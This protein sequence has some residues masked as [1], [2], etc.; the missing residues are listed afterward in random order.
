MISELFSLSALER[1]VDRRT[2]FSVGITLMLLKYVVDA[3]AIW[4][5]AGIL[6]TPFDYFVPLVSLTGA[7]IARFPTE[8]NAFLLCW[9]LIFIWIGVTMSARRA[10]DAGMLPWVV[11]CF[12]VPFL[13]Y[14]LML[15]L[16]LVPTGAVT[17]AP[18]PSNVDHPFES[19]RSTRSTVCGILAGASAGVATIVVGVLALRTYGGTLFLLTPFMVGVVSAFVANRIRPRRKSETIMIGLGALGLIGGTLLLFALEG[20]ICIAMAVPLAVPLQ[21][22]GSFLGHLMGRGEAPAITSISML[23]VLGPAA[24]AMDRVVPAA[25]TRIVMTSI[26]VNAPPDDVWKNVVSFSE[27]SASPAW[28]FRTGLAYPLRA[29]ISGAGPGAVRHCEFTTGAFVEPITI[30]DAPGRLAFDVA[31]Q[32]PPMQEWSPYARVYAPHLD[33]FFRTTH[34]EFR[35]IALEGGRTRLEGR[36]WYSLRM[37]PAIY[38]NVIADGIL[39]AVHQRVLEHVKATTESARRSRGAA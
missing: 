38:W 33:G 13:N 32:P 34:G 8:L 12:F 25:A 6:W 37:Q 5:A 16:A 26:E 36:T 11:V 35:L 22:M 30:W 39:H 14:I 27:I 17:R 4:W 21:V 19:R 1:P 23:L 3:T 2:Y 9:A 18:R 10:I 29:R 28:Y 24:S 7:K 20:A 31:A 15:V